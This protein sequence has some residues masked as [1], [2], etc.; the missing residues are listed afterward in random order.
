MRMHLHPRKSNKIM[1]SRLGISTVLASVRVVS[2]RTRKL[3]KSKVTFEEKEKKSKY[4]AIANG[5]GSDNHSLRALG[6]A[7]RAVD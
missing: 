1:T 3:P 5:S 7:L 4:S 6:V 2:C